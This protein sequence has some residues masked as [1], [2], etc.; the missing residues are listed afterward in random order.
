VKD[1]EDVLK[2]NPGSVIFARYAEELARNGKIDEA[3]EVLSNGINANPDYAAGYSVLAEINANQ[4]LHKAAIEHLEKSLSLEPQA[5]RDMF[6][7]G[8]YFI[9]NQPEKAKDYLWKAH[10]YEPEASDVKNALK[11]ALSKT[12]EAGEIDL[13]PE[14]ES[15][16]PE[17]V[18]KVK[19]S[20]EV[21]EPT[22][23][24]TAAD[25]DIPEES[26]EETEISLT[27]EGDETQLIEETETEEYLEEETGTEAEE[28]ITDE[29]TAKDIELAPETEDALS[30]LVGEVE[31]SEEVAEPG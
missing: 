6:N 25:E 23:D 15:L 28:L 4:K 13:L 7:L 26:R 18:G 22:E 9:N 30:G 16:H 2:E 14:K 12:D 3:I 1:P 20:E 10:Y 27:A 19:V 8:K 29:S 11:E 5:P 21:A 31:V 24:I 17:M